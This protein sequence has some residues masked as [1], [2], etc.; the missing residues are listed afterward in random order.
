M[1]LDY[2]D[3]SVDT[4]RAD[5]LPRLTQFPVTEMAAAAG[6]SE[7][8]LRDIYAGRATPRQPTKQ[9]LRGVLADLGSQP[10]A[11]LSEEPKSQSEAAI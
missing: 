2:R 9:R 5:D 11:R 10:M 1:L 3:P 8:R 4:W 6:L 7:R